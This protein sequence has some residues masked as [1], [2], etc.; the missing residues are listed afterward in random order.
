MPGPLAARLRVARWLRPIAF[1]IPDSAI[2][3][4]PPVKSMDWPAHVVDPEVA[5][6]VGGATS[7][8][9]EDAG[10]YH[11]DLRT[12]RFGITG[13]SGRGWD[14]LRHYEIAAAGAVPCFRDLESKPATCAPFGLD[15]GNSISYDSV[16]DLMRRIEVL[17]EDDYAR[18]QAGALRWAHANT[19]VIRARE[20][21]RACG[22]NPPGY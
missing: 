16:E 2:V 9:F 21:L 5:G 17:G 15:A 11:A 18:L 22:L 8:A 12:A 6:R 4:T 20:F 1:S 7:Y 14:A 10:A 13:P 3:E 19:T